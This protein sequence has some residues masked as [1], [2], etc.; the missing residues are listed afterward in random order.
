[1]KKIF[2]IYFGAK[3]MNYLCNA[4]DAKKREFEI[5]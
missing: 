3:G 2:S 5:N 4:T 1:M